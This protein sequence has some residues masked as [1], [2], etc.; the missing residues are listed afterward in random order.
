MA[1]AEHERP[2][3]SLAASRDRFSRTRLLRAAVQTAGRLPMGQTRR[4]LLLVSD[5][6]RDQRFANF[7]AGVVSLSRPRQRLDVLGRPNRIDD[8]RDL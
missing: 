4:H 5:F 7:D 2:T 1:G 3:P 6:E 8:R